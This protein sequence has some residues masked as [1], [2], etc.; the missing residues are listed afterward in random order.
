MF[1]CCS[2]SFKSVTS[3]DLIWWPAGA[4]AALRGFAYFL[5][6]LFFLHSYSV[7][8]QERGRQGVLSQG[9]RCPLLTSSE[10]RGMRKGGSRGRVKDI[11]EWTL[12]VISL[13]YISLCAVSRLMHRKMI[14]ILS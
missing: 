12:K 3:V 6:C 8:L 14:K 10:R 5:F 11:Q 7:T 4:R 1:M 2:L 13:R 9:V